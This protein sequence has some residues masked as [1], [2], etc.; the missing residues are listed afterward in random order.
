MY[1]IHIN[2]IYIHIIDALIF[3]QCI[4]LLLDTFFCISVQ[5]PYRYVF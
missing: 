5:R 1:N 4:P 3:V 2:I